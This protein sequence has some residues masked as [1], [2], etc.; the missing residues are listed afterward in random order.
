MEGWRTGIASLAITGQPLRETHHSQLGDSLHLPH[1]E[2]FGYQGTARS[3]AKLHSIVFREKALSNPNLDNFTC[4][5]ETMAAEKEK[6]QDRKTSKGK[7]T[8]IKSKK[9]SKS[10]DTES[11]SNKKS[12]GKKS[13]K[14][15]GEKTVENG[16]DSAGF[17]LLADAKVVDLKLSSLFAAKVRPIDGMRRPMY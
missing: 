11:K 10:D 4:T 8:E 5:N 9:K 7:D 3:G 16:V 6:K 2:T 12:K 17:C 14:D 13:L 1:S 15:L